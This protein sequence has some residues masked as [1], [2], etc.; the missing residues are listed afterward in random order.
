MPMERL[1]FLQLIRSCLCKSL[2][3]QPH[4]FFSWQLSAVEPLTGLLFTGISPRTATHFF[5]MILV[6]RGEKLC[7]K[8]VRLRTRLHQMINLIVVTCT[9]IMEGPAFGV[10]ADICFRRWLS[11]CY[12]TVASALGPLEELSEELYHGRI[13]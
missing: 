11:S 3:A 1:D 4:H 9:Y 13:S 2:Q 7:L 10:D 12:Y 5:L 6:R 8:K